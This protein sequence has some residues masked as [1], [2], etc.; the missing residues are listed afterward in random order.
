MRTFPSRVGRYAARVLLPVIAVVLMV[1]VPAA[2]VYYAYKIS[3]AM[4]TPASSVGEAYY[5]SPD[6]KYVVFTADREIDG[7]VN[8]YSVPVAGGEA[9]RISNEAA[10]GV[11]VSQLAISPD[12][13]RVV[14]RADANTDE[15]V[16]LFSVPIAGG[17]VTRLNA[18]LEA[19][20]DVTRFLI[21]PTGDFVIYLADHPRNDQFYL[22]HVP[23][24]GG[25]VTQA[26]QDLDPWNDVESEFAIT[27]GG[28]GVI[29]RATTTVS[30]NAH[31]FLKLLSGTGAVRELSSPLPAS[32]NV[33]SFK[34]IPNGSAVVY[35]ADE[36]GGVWN[37]FISSLYVDY[38]LRITD[39]TSARLISAYA[40]IANGTAVGYIAEHAVTAGKFELWVARIDG[41]GDPAIASAPICPDCDVE[42]FQVAPNGHDLVYKVLDA[43]GASRLH[44]VVAGVG[45][46]VITP[47][48]PAGRR[49]GG[50]QITPNSLGVMYLA[51]QDGLQNELYSVWIT[52]GP[53]LKLSQPLAAGTDVRKASVTLNSAGVLYIAQA[54]GSGSAALFLTPITAPQWTRLSRPIQVASGEVESYMLS[55]DGAWLVYQA[56][57]EVLDQEELYLVKDVKPVYLANV[58]K[59]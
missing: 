59:N 43:A 38:G 11:R 16:E 6:G 29:Y 36:G 15:V 39:S 3:G 27:T 58:G 7:A 2:G 48:L 4:Q 51:Q 57:A 46:T 42:E 8:I 12:S 17:T 30:Q 40:F 41:S 1:A 54:E 18:D 23:I 53:T 10:P 20:R 55:P 14:Y 35:R 34:I 22:Y 50:F 19:D 9:V 33:A 45:V 26:N 52:G 28:E 13:S 31:L 44:S 32:I 56:D 25:A 37:L 24:A 47:S 21:S 49:V 5:I